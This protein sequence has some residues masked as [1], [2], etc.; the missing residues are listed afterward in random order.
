MRVRWTTDA[1][2]D[3]ERI[4]EHIA[5][6][7][8]DAAIRTARAIYQGVAALATLPLRGRTR[9]VY[10]TRELVFTPLPYI[11]V[12]RVHGEVVQ[13]LHIITPRSTGLDEKDVSR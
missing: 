4:T 9:R 3:L 5:A 6:D 10:G 8:P 13:I 11:A 2:A 7:R 1:A 12:Y